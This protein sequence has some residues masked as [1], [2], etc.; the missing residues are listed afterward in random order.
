MALTTVAEN[1]KVI[2]WQNKVRREYIR[3]NRF[4]R[5]MGADE[6]KIIQVQSTLSAKRGDTVS[7][8]LVT[9]LTGGGVTGDNTLEGNEEALGNYEDRQTVDQLRHAVARGNMEQQRTLIDLLDEA[10]MMLKLWAQS[11]LR[12]DIIARMLCPN[13]DGVT[14]YADCSEADKDAW[15]TA[16][17]GSRI[18]Y[19][20]AKS[21]RSAGDHSASLLTVDATDDVLSP[22]IVSL[23]KRMARDASSTRIRPVVVEE[24]E[25]NFVLFCNKWA[26]RDFK[27]NSTYQQML[28]D[29]EVRGKGNPLYNDGDLYYDGVILREIVE[30]PVISGAGNGGIDVAPNFFCGAQDIW[31]DWAQRTRAISDSRDYGNIR[32]VGVQEIRGIKK[33][34]FNTLQ[35]GQLT[36]YTAGVADT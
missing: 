14:A 4:A 3:G 18:L 23:A 33:S 24:D 2:Q 5:Y 7:M 6:N 8:P 19:G 28:R 10:S 20:N 32:A 31:I 22:A 15:D 26:F 29:A 21:N 17:G 30:I 36:L 16:N 11:K 34:Y 27:N 13:L 1:N 12:D 9:E 25:E 35:F